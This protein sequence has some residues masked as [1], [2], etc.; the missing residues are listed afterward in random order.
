ML[1]NGKKWDKFP[2]SMKWQILI[3]IHKKI[4]NMKKN[5]VSEFKFLTHLI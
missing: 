3:I 1:K 2:K 4:E 5:C